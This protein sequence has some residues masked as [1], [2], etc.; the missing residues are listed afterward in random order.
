M[1]DGHSAT[2]HLRHSIEDACMNIMLLQS[3]LA[4]DLRMVTATFRAISDL[5]RIGEMSYETALLTQE[6]D[7]SLAPTFVQELGVM[8]QH[9]ATMLEKAVEAF[10]ASDVDGAN[11]VFALDDS[12]DEVFDA[13]RGQIITLLQQGSEA[14]A[15]APELF[16]IAKYYERM[17]DHAQSIADWAIFRATGDYRGMSMGEGE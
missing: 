4:S 1:I 12:L 8:S 9:A 6:V 10:M 7:L 5:A 3:P 13:I 17:G 15:I 11:A 14:A 16:T 2:E